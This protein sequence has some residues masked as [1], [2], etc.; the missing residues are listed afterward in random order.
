MRARARTHTHRGRKEER[1]EG[2]TEGRSLVRARL[3]IVC[4]SKWCYFDF[5]TFSF[6]AFGLKKYV[7]RGAL[8]RRCCKHATPMS[9]IHT[10]KPVEFILAFELGPSDFLSFLIFPFLFSFGARE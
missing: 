10:Y 6:F 4:D 8:F 7:L 2:F 5:L 9:R 3:I 1:G